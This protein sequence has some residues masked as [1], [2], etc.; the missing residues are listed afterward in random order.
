MHHEGKK[1]ANNPQ[2]QKW[3]AA[4]YKTNL[5]KNKNFIS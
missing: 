2:N 3:L 1:K 4:T 5:G